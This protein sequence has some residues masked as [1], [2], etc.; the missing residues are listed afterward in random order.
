MESERF[1]PSRI[2]VDVSGWEFDTEGHIGNVKSMPRGIVTNVT[3]SLFK[4]THKVSE[5]AVCQFDENSHLQ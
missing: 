4:K 3:V 2:S 1:Q 5:F